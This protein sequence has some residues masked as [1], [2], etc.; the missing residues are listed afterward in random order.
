M[1][2]N[3]EDYVLWPARR[4]LVIAAAA[5]IFADKAWSQRPPRIFIIA[6]STKNQ[7]Q[8]LMDA[9][10]SGLEQL[11]WKD[12]Q[13]AL[14]EYRYA[15][16][17]TASIPALA[18]EAVAARPAVIF[19][20]PEPVAVAVR[21]LTRDI[22][23]VFAIAND[24]VGAGLVA[25]LSRP[26]GNATGLSNVNVEVS[27]KRLELLREIAPGIER[28]AVLFNSKVA[29]EAVQV[30]LARQAG[31][32]LGVQIAEF[33]VA[34]KADLQP[35]F[36]RMASDRI[37]GLIVLADPLLFTQ[38]QLIADRARTL[39]LVSLGSF[40]EFPEAGGLAAYAV[41]FPAQF[42]RASSYVDKILR[43]ANP[44]DLPVEQPTRMELTIN[45]RTAKVI[46]L[47]IA[48]SYLIRAD[49]VIE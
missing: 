28:V 39:R 7:A 9:F 29:N 35:A 44:G 24:P 38:R 32:A 30:E 6:A 31:K 25:S 36:E 42:R 17:D 12:G 22:P 27:A 21:R 3:R 48:P 8:H 15:N 18:K 37:H 20:P 14:L 4:R 47:A 11:G 33:D 1:T 23:I 43:G 45:S 49:R 41:N 10:A 16:G 40:A 26:A 19:A 2:S 13:T 34:T 5:S 46:G